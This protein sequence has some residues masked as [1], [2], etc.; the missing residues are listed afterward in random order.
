[1][2]QVGF[3]VAL[4]LR[5]CGAWGAGVPQPAHEP[6]EL[7]VVGQ[8]GARGPFKA[9]PS[10]GPGPPAAT[11]QAQP[12]QII[13]TRL[14]RHVVAPEE[15]GRR[16][17][18][19]QGGHALRMRSCEQHREQAIVAAREDRGSLRPRRFHHDLE[20]VGQGLQRWVESRAATDPNSPTPAPSIV[21]SLAKESRRRRNQAGT[22]SP[23]RAQ[24]S[25]CTPE[26]GAS[27]S[28]R[29]P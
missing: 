23:N 10:E 26:G 24:R 15:A 1:M 22:G 2:A 7:P 4:D 29:S 17:V 20:I 12:I 16:V 6:L 11:T 13:R 18:Q 21:M 5:D 27:R 3:P 25:T 28:V 9:P 14:P 8:R 19:H